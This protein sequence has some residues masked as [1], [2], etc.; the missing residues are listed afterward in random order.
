MEIQPVI[1]LAKTNVWWTVTAILIGLIVRAVK[2][3]GPIPITLPAKWRPWL[4]VAL[5][6]VSTILN[7]VATG[8]HWKDALAGGMVAALA[9]ISGHELLVESA[10]GG[11]ELGE[12]KPDFVKRSLP[13]PPP[14]TVEA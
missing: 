7:K 10:R 14:P 13:P 5:G 2:S 11:R 9:S 8:T 12:S 3:D 4:A 1:E 6:I